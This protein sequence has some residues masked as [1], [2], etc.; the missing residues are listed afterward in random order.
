MKKINVLQLSRALG[1]G[2]T[3]KTL[4]LYT[5]SLNKELFT[6]TVCGLLKGG[7]RGE[8]L[9]QKGYEVYVINGDKLDLLNLMR[10]KKFDILHIHSLGDFNPLPIEAAIATNIPV[11]VQTNIFAEIHNNPLY[12]DNVDMHFFVS[13]WGAV[14]SKRLLR[15]SWEKFFTQH[16]VLFNPIDFSEIDNS[17]VHNFSQKELFT[18]Y[19]IPP[20]YFVIGRHGR[21]EPGKWGNILVDM[22]PRLLK[23]IPTIKFLVMGF[24]IEK[25]SRIDKMGLRDN[26][27]FLE[28]TVEMERINELIAMS[29]VFPTSSVKGES[30]GVVIAEAMAW[31]KP[32]VSNSLPLRDNAQVELIDHGKT[33]FIAN[34]S[35]DF[36]EAIA[37]LLTNEDKRRKMGEA[38]RKKAEDNYELKKN[39]RSLEKIYIRLLSKKGVPIPESVR[40]NYD[41]VLYHPSHEEIMSFEKEYKIRIRSC[42]GT[43]NYFD[44]YS[45]ELLLS[46]PTY[47][48]FAKKLKYFYDNKLS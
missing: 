21:P 43:P 33:G 37:Y 26:F 5:E 35:K 41:K 48:N 38:A 6:V 3:E 17:Q 15:Q 25:V 13:K 42:W 39:T 23:S 27:I 45:S 31:R 46:N 36:A 28:P 20:E 16:H 34:T 8:I 12:N 29:D 11:I 1:I 19:N 10:E 47:Y 9:T 32:V 30:F 24:P 18:K 40:E 2:G 7:A 22:M 14:K 44:I 4:Q